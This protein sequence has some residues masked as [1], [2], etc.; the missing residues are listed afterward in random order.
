[1]KEDNFTAPVQFNILILYNGQDK[2]ETSFLC[3]YYIEMGLSDSSGAMVFVLIVF[4][5]LRKF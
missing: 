3:F 5:A 1:M 4:I 2:T